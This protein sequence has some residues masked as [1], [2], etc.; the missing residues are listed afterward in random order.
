MTVSPIR[1][2]NQGMK[3][4]DLSV[5]YA[6]VCLP[7]RDVFVWI[8]SKWSTSRFRCESLR[9]ILQVYLP[10]VTI[11]W[12]S[13]FFCTFVKRNIFFLSGQCPVGIRKSPIKSPL[14]S[15][16]GSTFRVFV[17]FVFSLLKETYLFVFVLCVFY[18]KPS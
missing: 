8:T 9:R 13:E 16:Y 12:C 10:T 2:Y 17:Y 1:Y 7:S 4:S 6:C 18:K 14:T 3:L 15:D 5:Q 11:W